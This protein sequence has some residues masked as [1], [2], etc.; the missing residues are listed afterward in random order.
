MAHTP[1]QYDSILNPPSKPS[2]TPDE[3]NRLTRAV[4]GIILLAVGVI[5]V[6]GLLIQ[7]KQLLLGPND[8]YLLK[9]LAAESQQVVVQ[10]GDK[11]I[12][13]PPQLPLVVG[14]FL[15]VL[16]LWIAAKLAHAFLSLGTTVLLSSKST[17]TSSDEPAD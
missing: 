1:T 2:P 10:W 13:F 4:V 9:R 14:Y 8:P 5:V 12:E 7:I 17:A 6:V 11:R 3:A 15:A 16:L